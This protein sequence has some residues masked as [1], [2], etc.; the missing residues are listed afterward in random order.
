MIEVDNLGLHVG[1]F[2][3]QN[4]SLQV[5]SGKWAVLMGKSGSGKTTLLEAICG[6]RRVN[7]GAI[8]LHGHDMTQVKPAGREIGYVPQDVSLFSTMTVREHLAFA[9]TIRRWPKPAMAQRVQELAEFLGL[10]LLLDR[11]PFGLS[12][13][14]AQRVALGRALACRP[15]VLCLDE[16]LSALDEDTKEEM[17]DLLKSVQMHHQVTTLYVT[18]NQE[19]AKRLADVVLRMADGKVIWSA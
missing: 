19:D 15:R 18:H 17:Y 2:S 10:T 4:I 1:S 8:R 13:G 9:L 5:P 12:G 16:P 14:E 7:S 3:L 6:L 11:K